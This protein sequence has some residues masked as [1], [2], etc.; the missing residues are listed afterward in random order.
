MSGRNS[1]LTRNP[2]NADFNQYWYSAKTI[3]ALAVEL[4]EVSAG[5]VAFLSTPSVYF[6]MSSETHR[7]QSRFFDIDKKWEKHPQFVYYD[8]NEPEA[9]PADLC[10]K[11]DAILIDPPFI[12]REVWEKYA[13][14]A[15]L[16]AAPGCKIVLSTIQENQD[17]MLELLDVKPQKFLPSIPNLVYQYFLYCSYESARFSESNPEIPE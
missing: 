12:T 11:F 14:A 16:L 15:R 7:E 8:F 5:P 13:A 2:E 4:E 3:E 10:G 17:M 9:I 6:S 1:F